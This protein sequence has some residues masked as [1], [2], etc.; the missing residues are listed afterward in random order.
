MEM[1]KMK[2][3]DIKINNVDAK[4]IRE[5]TIHVKIQNYYPSDYPFI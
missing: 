5:E 4:D 1:V 3:N 2:P